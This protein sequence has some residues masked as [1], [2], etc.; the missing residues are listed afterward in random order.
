M[1][2]NM[3]TPGNRLVDI[4]CDHGFLPVYLVSRGICPGA[5]AM[6]VREGPLGAA[7]RHV[8]EYGLGNYIEVRLSDGLAEY[9][10]GEAETMVCA[11]LGGRLMERILRDGLDKAGQMRELI[12]QPQSELPQF[13]A[14]LRETGFVVIEE[15]AVLEDG[16][17]YFAMKARRKSSCVQAQD[18]QD[19]ASDLSQVSDVAERMRLYDCYGRLLLTQRHPVLFQYL[20]QR[21]RYI[22]ELCV[23]L[24]AAS[25]RGRQR[26]AQLK[27]E[28]G[29]IQRALAFFNKSV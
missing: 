28:Q 6:D 2:A 7:R 14:F 23:S 15:N 8:E 9:K 4:G 20:K 24:E 12:L 25:E 16:K 13:R 1:L 21:E 11:G 22:R 19:A 17:Y 18:V 26:A 5:V 3:V 27:E 29:E 10:A